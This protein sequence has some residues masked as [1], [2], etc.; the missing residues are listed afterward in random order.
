MHFVLNH[1]FCWLGVVVNLYLQW[2][3]SYYPSLYEWRYW[4]IILVNQGFVPAKRF[5]LLSWIQPSH[6]FVK[7]Y[8]IHLLFVEYFNYVSMFLKQHNFVVQFL[9]RSS[10]NI[11]AISVIMKKYYAVEYGNDYDSIHCFNIFLLK[12]TKINSYISKQKYGKNWRDTHYLQLIIN[13]YHVKFI[14]FENKIS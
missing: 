12:D 9:R 3:S 7:E 13:S 4:K 2:C 11:F 10:I 8:S 6:Y 5:I 14:S 1:S